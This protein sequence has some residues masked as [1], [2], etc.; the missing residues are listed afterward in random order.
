MYIQNRKYRKK[1][2]RSN[3]A[4]KN[5]NQTILVKSSHCARCSGPHK[6]RGKKPWPREKF[7]SFRRSFFSGIRLSGIFLRKK[8]SGDGS[9]LKT[10]DK[11]TQG[12]EGVYL[13]LATCFVNDPS[14]LNLGNQ[15]RALSFAVLKFIPDAISRAKRFVYALYFIPITLH[16]VSVPCGVKPER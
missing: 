10:N 6:I 3:Y 15:C 14:E 13:L 16:G 12:D 2:I 1:I 7:L 9:S 4:L 11:S 5:K 8:A